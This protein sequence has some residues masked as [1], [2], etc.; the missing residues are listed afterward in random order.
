MDSMCEGH[1]SLQIRAFL[2]PLTQSVKINRKLFS[3]LIIPSGPSVPA[4]PPAPPSK[5]TPLPRHFFLK[6]QLWPKCCLELCIFNHNPGRGWG[7]DERRQCH[8]DHLCCNIKIKAATVSFTDPGSCVLHVK[9]SHLT[10][11]K[12]KKEKKK[13][14]QLSKV[15]SCKKNYI[16]LF[17]TSC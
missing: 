17:D 12:N 5:K 4:S 6:K 7:C 11:R 2:K 3:P 15:A 16:T 1:C 14:K 13:N 9:R 8:R 10:E